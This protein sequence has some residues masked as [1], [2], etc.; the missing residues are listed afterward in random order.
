M[1]T[2]AISVFAG[3]SFLGSCDLSNAQSTFN[4]NSATIYATGGSVIQVNGGMALGGTSH[5]QNEGSVNIA[6]KNNPGTFAI[7]DNS[8]VQGS[9][10][11]RVEQDW[12]NNSV[13]TANKS[14]VE[15]NG[16][17]PQFIGGTVATTFHDLQLTGTGTGPNRKKNLL[18]TNAS[19]DASGI[20]A[21]NDRELDTDTNTFFVQNTSATCV[22]NNISLGSEGFVSSTSSGTFSRETNSS[23]VYL[24]PTGSSLGVTRYRPVE[25]TP[26]FSAANT[27]T[28]RLAN[29]DA[30]LDLCPVSNHSARI[31]N[32]NPYFYHKIRHPLGLDH[33]DV[34]I[35]YD[36][37]VDG[38][39]DGMDQWNV[40]APYMW[41]DMSSV[42]AS[43]SNV[44]R[45]DWS[46]FNQDQFILANEKEPPVIIPNVFSPD[47]DGQNDFFAISDANFEAFHIEIFDRWGVKMF[48]SYAAVLAW[49]G[50]N[51]A[52][53]PVTEGTYFFILKAITKKTKTDFSKNGFLTLMRKK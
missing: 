45:S 22:T 31:A 53:Q 19:I 11:Y 34:S 49:D 24:F 44:N 3:F 16:S 38:N 20:L 15:L 25:I 1:K 30:T 28:A 47:G 42:S 40:P 18:A 17:T 51:L 23:A 36:P 35:F 8:V 50:T 26:D 32:L 2:T 48:E 43:G 13:F 52:G 4:S 27:F 46:D 6:T 37:S 29:N 9:G 33:A 39:Y 5:L 12:L 10:T 14:T 41:N 7:N 21:I